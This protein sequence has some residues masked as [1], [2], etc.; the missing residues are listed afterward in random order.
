MSEE[1]WVLLTKNI[2]AGVTGTDEGV[3]RRMCDPKRHSSS[4]SQELSAALMDGFK[5]K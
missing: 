3:R 2:A 4:V 5:D 1:V